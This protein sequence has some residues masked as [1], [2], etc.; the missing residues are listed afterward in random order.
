[1]ERTVQG[2]LWMAKVRANGIKNKIIL[3]V[4]LSVDGEQAPSRDVSLFFQTPIKVIPP[5][6]RLLI[7]GLF[8]FNYQHVFLRTNTHYALPIFKLTASKEMLRIPGSYNDF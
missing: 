6:S 3:M 2:D 4:N 8:F 7:N 5:N 1:M